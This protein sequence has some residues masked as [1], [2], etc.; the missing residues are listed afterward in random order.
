MDTSVLVV[1]LFPTDQEFEINLAEGTFH[2]Q[3][4]RLNTIVDW[5]ITRPGRGIHTH[6]PMPIGDLGDGSDKLAAHV[7]G[8]LPPHIAPHNQM[9]LT[10]EDSQN[11]PV[12]RLLDCPRYRGHKLRRAM[13]EIAV[14]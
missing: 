7:I 3:K 12:V 4:R 1:G 6:E 13:S 5:H 8:I 9:R 2:A 11:P 10:V 14:P